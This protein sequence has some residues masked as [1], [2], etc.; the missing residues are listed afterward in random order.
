MH[1]E[2]S[3]HA[4]GSDLFLFCTKFPKNI[5]LTFLSKSFLFLPHECLWYWG[6]I[7]I[8]VSPWPSDD[9]VTLTAGCLGP[10]CR[11]VLFSLPHGTGSPSISLTVALN[12]SCRHLSSTVTTSDSVQFFPLLATLKKR[13]EKNLISCSY[14]LF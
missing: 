6:L 14:Y 7:V 10:A 4:P 1:P 2:S 9:P 12:V 5:W 3:T 11:G 8:I 13:K